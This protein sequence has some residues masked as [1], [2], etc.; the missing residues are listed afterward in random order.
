QPPQ[1]LEEASPERGSRRRAPVR[2]GNRSL[3][4]LTPPT[5]GAPDFRRSEHFVY[6]GHWLHGVHSKCWETRCPHLCLTRQSGGDD[7]D[8]MASVQEGS[9]DLG[10]AERPHSRIGW[11][12]VSD[13][14]YWT[15]HSWPCACSFFTR[16]NKVSAITVCPLKL[17]WI[18]SQKYD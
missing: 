13:Q 7:V 16:S 15:L 4:L 14:H 18:V 1:G 11:K 17:G 6:V 5:L 12:V 9:C 3:G 2:S 8:T 10:R